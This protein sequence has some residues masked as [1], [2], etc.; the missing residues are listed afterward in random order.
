MDKIA[1]SIDNDTGKLCENGY[2]DF[3]KSGYYGK[4]HDGQISWG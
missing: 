4:R 3:L 2:P 1:L